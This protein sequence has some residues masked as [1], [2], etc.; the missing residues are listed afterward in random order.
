MWR[1]RRDSIRGRT[2]ALN[3]PYVPS[4][5]V[6]YRALMSGLLPSARIEGP[7]HRQNPEESSKELG[8]DSWGINDGRTIGNHIR[9]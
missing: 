7:L 9:G 1:Q 4:R 6:R 5:V 8:K 2:K 3:G